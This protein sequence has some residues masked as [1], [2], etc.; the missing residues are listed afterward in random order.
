MVGFGC[1]LLSFKV[2]LAKI[3]ADQPRNDIC[4][5]TDREE[6]GWA[7]IGHDYKSSRAESFGRCF[8]DCIAKMKKVKVQRFCGTLRNAS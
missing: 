1:T 4:Q 8:F 7:L 5:D 3:I 2:H 6:F